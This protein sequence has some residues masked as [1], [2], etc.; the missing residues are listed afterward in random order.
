[1]GPAA[2]GLERFPAKWIPVRVKKTR[3]I[4]NLA[5]KLLQNGPKRALTACPGLGHGGTMN[6]FLAICSVCREIIS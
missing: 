4:K 5:A 2:G 6:G 3:Q 1:M